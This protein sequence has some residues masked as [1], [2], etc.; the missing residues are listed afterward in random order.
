MQIFASWK[1]AVILA[2]VCKSNQSRRS[3]IVL[4]SIVYS[5]LVKTFPITNTV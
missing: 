1:F 4:N 5:D 3:S 2:F